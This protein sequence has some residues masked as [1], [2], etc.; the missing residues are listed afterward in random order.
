MVRVRRGGKWISPWGKTFAAATPWPPAGPTQ[1]ISDSEHGINCVVFP[2]TRGRA[3]F[4]MVTFLFWNIHKR[5]LQDLIVALAREHEVDVIMLAECRL[6]EHV[7]LEG[8]NEGEAHYHFAHGL[9]E[10]VRVFTRFSSEFLVPRFESDRISL[11]HLTLPACIEVLLA[12][13][14]LPSKLHFSEKSMAFECVALSKKIREQEAAL[15][16]SRTVVVGDLNMN[17]FE[18]GVTGTE[19][20]HAVMS[21]EVASR[22]SRT[23]QERPYP[24]F[25][26]PMWSRFGDRPDGPPGTYY[27]DRSEHVTYFWNIFDQVLIRPELVPRLDSDGPTVLS[28]VG[29]TSLLAPDGRPDQRGA[30]DHLPI[31]FRLTL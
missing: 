2:E 8:L 27:Y 6:P 10:A 22:G 7:L 26:N 9:C 14:H 16:H 17:P 4:A 5:P 19:G 21:R 31:L 25:Y 23:V 24:F 20:L 29:G 28:K 18:D 15:G 13:V 3:A 12:I 11:R 1:V 30:S